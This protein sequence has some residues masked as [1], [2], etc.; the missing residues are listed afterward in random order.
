MVDRMDQGAIPAQ[1]VAQSYDA[2][3]KLVSKALYRTHV[4]GKLK[5]SH[6]SPVKCISLLSSPGRMLKTCSTL[7][8]A[9][10][11]LVQLLIIQHS[12]LKTFLL[13]GVRHKQSG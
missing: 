9:Y 12:Y 6:S 13:V 2:L 3:W 4:E 7:Q 11:R 8:D 10:S 5:V 1:V